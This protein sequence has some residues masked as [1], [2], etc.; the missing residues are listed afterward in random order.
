MLGA[1]NH[2]A[3][4]F[5]VA[6]FRP[7][8]LATVAVIVMAVLTPRAAAWCDLGLTPEQKQALEK[9]ASD[10]RRQI[11]PLRR[12][13]AEKRRTLV[14]LYAQYNLDEKKARETTATINNL[15]RRLLDANLQN[16]IGLRQI[17]T[18]DQFERFSAGLRMKRGRGPKHG[19][20][21]AMGPG[22]AESFVPGEFARRE[23][24]RLDLSPEQ[25]ERV[26][27]LFDTDKR[28]EKSPVKQLLKDV[29]SV[30]ALY[31]NYDL[32]ERQVRNL[33]DRINA[34]QRQLLE[35]SL[36]RQIQIRDILTAAQFNRLVEDIRRGMRM[37]HR[38]GE[39]SPGR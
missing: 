6:A 31:S 33:L 10:T 16:Q 22:A 11:M 32:D 34:A 38:F 12:A 5:K 30:T 9:L 24:E 36:A 17:L 28:G 18:R 23:V 21:S 35:L 29:A 39:G 7:Q 25:L 3:R 20:R 37:R 4:R 2:L 19:P 8:V 14:E 13:L 26:Q 15:Q 27:R 1:D